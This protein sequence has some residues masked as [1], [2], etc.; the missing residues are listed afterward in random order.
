MQGAQVRVYEWGLGENGAVW[1]HGVGGLM[2]GD[3]RSPGPP[4]VTNGGP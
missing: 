1:I 2:R 4:L 3:G